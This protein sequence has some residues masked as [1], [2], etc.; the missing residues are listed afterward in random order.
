MFRF[1]RRWIFGAVECT[2]QSSARQDML[3]H[4]IV[5]LDGQA[6]LVKDRLA[7]LCVGVFCVDVNA[8][9]VVEVFVCCLAFQS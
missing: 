8:P 5:A 1:Q 3:A 4:E 6:V 9:R 7:G 2:E